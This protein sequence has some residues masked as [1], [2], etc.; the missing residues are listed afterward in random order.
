MGERTQCYIQSLLLCGSQ[1]WYAIS[2][3]F[4]EHSVLHEEEGAE[5]LQHSNIGDGTSVPH[6]GGGEGVPLQHCNPSTKQPT[7]H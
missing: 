1:S 5:S 2:E 7:N 6:H 3:Q 4:Y